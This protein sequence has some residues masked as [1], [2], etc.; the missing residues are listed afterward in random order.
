MSASNTNATIANFSQEQHTLKV[1]LFLVVGLMIWGLIFNELTESNIVA[2][3][4]GAYVV[5]GIIGLVT[6]YVSKLSDKPKNT[7]HPLG[8]SGL[9]PVLNL[10]R[11]FMITLI[12]LKGI[13]ESIG[14]IVSGPEDTDHNILYT[15]AGVTLLFNV[16]GYVYTKIKATKLNSA[17]LKTDNIEWKIDSLYNVAI[18]L[19]VTISYGLQFTQ[20]K[21][22]SDYVDPAFCIVLS[23]SMVYA[24][25]MLFV[26]NVKIL[27][28]SKAD[29]KTQEAIVNSFNIHYPEINRYHPGFTV[30]NIAGTLWLDIELR[31][32]EEQ[33]ITAKEYIRI[34][35]TGE[36]VLKK[37]TDD[38]TISFRFIEKTTDIDSSLAKKL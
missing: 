7:E 30:L 38:F 11:S 23:A 25:I 1:S 17:L 26:E 6:I 24:P 31:M 19:A 16:F 27:S 20:Y 37:I 29:I 32:E 5:S 2:L 3:D 14:T 8:Y 36:I 33:H 4:A 9:I 22:Y 21:T 12:C 18:L 10:V 34:K 15:Y 35:T 28:V 13:S